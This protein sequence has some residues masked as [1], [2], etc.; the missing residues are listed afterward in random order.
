[1][2]KANI[3]D[4]S[5]WEFYVVPTSEID[6]RFKDQKSISLSVLKEISKSVK[7]SE[8]KACVDSKLALN[9]I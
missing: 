2:I 1:M 9:R 3:M 7:Y 6:N 4:I 8:L 5:S